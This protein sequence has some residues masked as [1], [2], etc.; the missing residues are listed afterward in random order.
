MGGEQIA[1]VENRVGCE[2]IFGYKITEQ[3]C[4][5]PLENTYV[6]KVGFIYMSI[7]AMMYFTNKG[8]CCYYCNIKNYIN[9]V[10]NKLFL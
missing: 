8:I 5:L 4:V 3:I 10:D 7:K 2:V 9:Y 6:R 1:R